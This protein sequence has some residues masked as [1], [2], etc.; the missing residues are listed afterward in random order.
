[1]NAIRAGRTLKRGGAALR[2]DVDA[3]YTSRVNL[4]QELH[5]DGRTP[6]RAIRARETVHMLS[7]AIAGLPS[8]LR[9]VVS[10]S[11]LDGLSNREIA[12]RIGKSESMVSK[13]LHQGLSELRERLRSATLSFSALGGGEDR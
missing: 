9:N 10:L 5:S 2:I 4:L 13:L 1:L 12:V 7:V 8:E 3:L 11:R 6:S